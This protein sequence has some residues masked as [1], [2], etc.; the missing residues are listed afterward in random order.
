MLSVENLPDPSCSYKISGLKGDERATEKLALQEADPVQPGLFSIRH[1]VFTSRSKDIGTNW[2]FPPKFLQLC[3]KHGVKE[4]LPPFEPPD[5][6]RGQ[7]SVTPSV[8]DRQAVRT[9][10][11]EK[12]STEVDNLDSDKDANGL[13]DVGV[14]DIEAKSSDPCV[15]ENSEKDPTPFPQEDNQGDGKSGT[16]SKSS[17]LSEGGREEESTITVAAPVQ[18][19]PDSVVTERPCS[20]VPGIN[21]KTQNPVVVS[22]KSRNSSEPQENKR[23]LI[24]KLGGVSEYSSRAEELVSNSSSVLD[25]MASKVC[26]VCK[27]F[28]ST[29]NTTLNAHIDQCL[30]EE[31]TAKREV[32]QFDKPHKVKPRKK[33][34]M[35]DICATAPRCTLEEL[36]RR[37]GLTRATDSS[38][39]A[40]N[41]EAGT[42]NKRPRW[43]P[44]DF[45]DEGNDSAVYVDSSGTKIRIL[46]RFNDA[47]AP[48][49]AED[50]NILS[51]KK[52]PPGLRGSKTLKAKSQT[53]KFSSMKQYKGEVLKATEIHQA[54]NQEKGEPLSQLLKTRDPERAT[55]PPGTLRQWVCSKRTGLSKKSG[56]KASIFRDPLHES[57]HPSI[58]RSHILRLSR[59]P[60][61]LLSS[62]KSKREETVLGS[63]TVVDNGEG[64]SQP[65]PE[66]DVDMSSRGPTLP[67]SSASKVARSPG[68][69]VSSP[70]SKRVEVDANIED[71]HSSASARRISSLRKS[72]FPGQSSPP[73]KQ[74]KWNEKRVASRNSCKVKRMDQSRPQTRQSL[75]D[76]LMGPRVKRLN[77]MHGINK[78]VKESVVEPPFSEAS[79]GEK[80]VVSTPE[81]SSTF[82]GSEKLDSEAGGSLSFESD[83]SASSPNEVMVG[84]GASAIF[85]VGTVCEGAYCESEMSEDDGSANQSVMQSDSTHLNG[86]VLSAAASGSPM[87]VDHNPQRFYGHKEMGSHDYAA[88]TSSQIVELDP[89]VD[90]GS[91]SE[92]QNTGSDTDAM[93]MQGSEL[94]LP[95]F[96][97]MGY[98]VLHGNS[99]FAASTVQSAQDTERPR[100]TS[101]S[102]VSATS[103]DS[104]T[105]RRRSLS[106][107]AVLDKVSGSS[108]NGTAEL[109]EAVD[110]I[111]S[112]TTS[113]SFNLAG[114]E[115]NMKLDRENLKITIP[116]NN[117][118]QKISDDQPCCCS[119]K[120]NVSRMYSEPQIFKQSTLPSRVVPKG[121]QVNLGIHNNRPENS[122]PFAA[123]PSS[124][125]DTP[126]SE[127]PFTSNKLHLDTSR[128]LPN[129]G[130]FGLVSPSSSQLHSQS[131]SSPVLRLMG[132][133]LMVVNKDEDEPVQ[134][135][136]SSLGTTTDQSNSKY[137]TLLGFSGGN[138][139]NQDS[140]AIYHQ[141]VDGSGVYSQDTCSLSSTFGGGL[142]SSFRG[143]NS[144]TELPMPPQEMWV[145]G[146]A[147]PA[148]AYGYKG[149]YDSLV[150]Q[151]RVVSRGF[152]SPSGF[153]YNAER[154][155][156]HQ[157]TRSSRE[158][159]IIDD[160]PELDSDPSMRAGAS[161]SRIN[162]FGYGTIMSPSASNS[163]PGKAFSSYSTQS[164]FLRE[165]PGPKPSFLM[166]CP[167][168]NATSTRLG[169]HESSGAFP[170]SPFLISST[171]YLNSST[172]YYTSSPK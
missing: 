123:S 67:D 111:H 164:T 39:A 154:S 162:Q 14:D 76:E 134:L 169:N 87:W 119:R 88:G 116:T 1:Y 58:Q 31:S 131:T 79:E 95:S 133:N 90:E 59:R 48:V 36:E 57:N 165:P 124:R 20:S 155:A 12:A 51:G 125:I 69:Y 22:E 10:G 77:K 132:K 115:R 30:S 61:N 53:K 107:S 8:S 103:T 72:G 43:G 82:S 171:G 109:V 11:E 18:A 73:I 47:P 28:S 144:S 114:A 121:K 62:P 97:D 46:S 45:C 149:K 34:S 159:I 38:S 65:S 130:D 150:Q 167:G 78:K 146:F 113:F 141:S 16:V 24:V 42:E 56:E 35:V 23:R 110:K 120:E 104:P 80:N 54:K 4:I 66:S 49:V 148:L 91:L 41:E 117:V 158:V 25:P 140:S 81:G 5:S 89:G 156:P 122:T 112:S 13:L 32:T 137:L 138:A 44:T 106:P 160:T 55:G 168:A 27:T 166:S 7:S 84:E 152:G 157:V 153:A 93:P 9:E 19:E 71:H 6:V 99:S 52:N 63:S 75:A 127:S 83:H 94:C 101:T 68:N 163:R 33:R 15:V 105:G 85:P 100:D 70:R 86:N 151:K 21:K 29:S 129:C 170:Q 161:G 142:S 139:L 17:G 74:N 126:T 108:S 135:Q 98:D 40:P 136:K 26:P 60:E 64:M 50:R 147:G 102:P 128:K 118:L 37:N 145:G 172:V 96:E 3:L 2:P 143:Q 92:A